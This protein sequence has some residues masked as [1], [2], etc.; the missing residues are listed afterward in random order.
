MGAEASWNDRTAAAAS[1]HGDDPGAT[2]VSALHSDDPLCDVPQGY[3]MEVSHRNATP[4]RSIA[5]QR[6]Q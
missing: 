4:Y 6:H 2:S 1:G 3:N 5:K